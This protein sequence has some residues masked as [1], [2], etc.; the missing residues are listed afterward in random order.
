[1]LEMLGAFVASLNA[2]ATPVKFTLTF[3]RDTIDFLDIRIFHTIN[4]VG[5]RPLYI[6]KT[7]IEIQHYMHTV[8]ISPLF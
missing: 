7:Q 1:M 4:G 2:L 5:T 6:I 8:S 3:D